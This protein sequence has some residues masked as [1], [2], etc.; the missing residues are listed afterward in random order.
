M[1]KVCQLNTAKVLIKIDRNFFNEYGFGTASL[2]IK[3][4]K[5]TN[6]MINHNV[7]LTTNKYEIGRVAMTPSTA[8]YE[9]KYQAM[10]I[11][12][13]K[14]TME[15]VDVTLD[16]LFIMPLELVFEGE[17][18]MLVILT[19]KRIENDTQWPSSKATRIKP[20]ELAKMFYL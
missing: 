6:T 3:Y 17:I 15:I 5:I 1:I 14:I 11:C 7:W 20:L 13:Y 10:A 8:V 2:I 19:R 9:I 4:V 16:E 12:P 18:L